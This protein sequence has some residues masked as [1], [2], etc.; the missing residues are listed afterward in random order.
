[1]TTRVWRV[2]VFEFRKVI[3]WK[4]LYVSFAIALIG[5]GLASVVPEVLSGEWDAESNGYTLFAI[6]SHYATFPVASLLCVVFAA[7]LVGQEYTHGTIAPF[8]A[9]PVRRYEML[10]GKTL[11]AL[12]YNVVIIGIVFSFGFILAY[13]LQ[14][15]ETIQ[16][17]KHRSITLLSFL[18][19]MSVA[20]IAT[21]LPLL[22]VSSVVMAITLVTEN[23]GFSIGIALSAGV[24]LPLLRFFQLD[25]ERVSVIEFVGRP[26]S[27]LVEIG[28][29][30]QVEWLY[31]LRMLGIVS[32]VTLAAGLAFMF[33]LFSCKKIV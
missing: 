23:A 17:D 15:F 26:T 7:L 9:T 24:I 25:F 1:M 13:F 14:G 16:I 5:C 28:E 31:E 20:A 10:L 2:F 11:L 32:G 30:I 8:A 22:A 33:V 19:D 29:E 12:C 3:R 6:I 4:Y 27:L 18:G 21:V